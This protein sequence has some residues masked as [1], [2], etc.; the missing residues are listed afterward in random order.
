LHLPSENKLER[1][2][3]FGE[4]VAPAPGVK[5]FMRLFPK[6]EEAHTAGV[7][8][9]PNHPFHQARVRLQASRHTLP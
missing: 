5:P 3:I 8:T 9:L 6:S 2:V 4:G 1:I 7:L